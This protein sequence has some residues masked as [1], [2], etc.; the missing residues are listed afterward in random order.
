MT[1]A[2]L[3]WGSSSK[4][5]NARVTIFCDNKAV[6]HMLNKSTSSCPKCLKLIQLITLENI[7]YNRRVFVLHVRTHDNK[8]ADALSRLNFKKF[9]SLAP[10]SMD[11]QPTS[12]PSVIWPIQKVWNEEIKYPDLQVLLNYNSFNNN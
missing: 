11:K 3:V 2:L 12:M 6:V 9:W 4:L 1:A 10:K 5:C 7:K 8:L